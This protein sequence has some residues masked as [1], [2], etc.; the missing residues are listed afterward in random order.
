MKMFYLMSVNT[1][2][3]VESFNIQDVNLTERVTGAKFYASYDEALN[4]AAD[5]MNM[6]WGS[7]GLY[8]VHEATVIITPNF[9]KSA[10]EQFTENVDKCLE[11]VAW[12]DDLTDQEANSLSAEMYD[13]YTASRNYLRGLDSWLK[14]D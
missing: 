9:A 3:Y 8:S 14:S 2:L 7:T 11:S 5:L 10:K 4:A 12:Y 13:Q 1:G 6:V